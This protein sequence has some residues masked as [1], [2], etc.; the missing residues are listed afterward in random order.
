MEMI[1]TKLV[2]GGGRWES[3]DRGAWVTWNGHNFES[4]RASLESEITP[5]QAEEDLQ[6]N[7]ETLLRQFLG[8]EDLSVR[9]AM[10]N[11]RGSS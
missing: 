2:Q 1:I 6:N 5:D 7:R 3:E 4:K 10:A 9:N 8:R 11:V